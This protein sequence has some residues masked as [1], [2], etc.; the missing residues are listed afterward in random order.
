MGIS[1]RRRPKSVQASLMQ[2][3][4]RV[5]AANDNSN[6]MISC[7]TNGNNTNTE[8]TTTTTTTNNNNN[9][10]SSIIIKC[11]N[12]DNNNSDTNKLPITSAAPRRGWSCWTR[13]TSCATNVT[14]IK[15]TANNNNKHNSNNNHITIM[16]LI[17][18][19][20]TIIRSAAGLGRRPALP[21]VRKRLLWLW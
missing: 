7:N 20:I 3:R 16:I 11:N 8:N 13:P 6:S 14:M 18:I 12:N 10:S 21:R 19:M 17:V 2:R 15:L 4:E 1:G 5:E 9:N